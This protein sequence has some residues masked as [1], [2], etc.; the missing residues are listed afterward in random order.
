M[1][2]N[3][4]NVAADNNNTD[5]QYFSNWCVRR[6]PSGYTPLLYA[7]KQNNIEAIAL[8]IDNGAD[9]RTEVTPETKMSA[10]HRAAAVGNYNVC[11]FL[12]SK[13][14]SEIKRMKDARG[15]TPFDW[16]ERRMFQSKGLDE[17]T[18]ENLLKLL[19]P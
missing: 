12:I 4:N 3:N 19:A 11:E 9:V 5:N 10:L 6:C 13:G 14:G 15:L 1:V 8:L 2:R 7:A 18:R 16:V 17:Q